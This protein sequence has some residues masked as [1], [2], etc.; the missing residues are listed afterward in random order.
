VR[1][2]QVKWKPAL[3]LNRIAP[4]GQLVMI[5][6]LVVLGVVLLRRRLN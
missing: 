2:G 1:N 5:T 3:D 4:R 6:A